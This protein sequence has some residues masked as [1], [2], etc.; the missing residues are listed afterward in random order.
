ME[1]Q[2]RSK[3]CEFEREIFRCQSKNQVTQQLCLKY[4]CFLSFILKISDCNGN[5]HAFIQ[6]N[7]INL[8]LYFIKTMGDLIRRFIQILVA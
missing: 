4:N 8:N 6:Y 1:C 2:W 7:F 5:Q 3:N